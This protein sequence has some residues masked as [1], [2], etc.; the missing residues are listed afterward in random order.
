MSV[1][2]YDKTNVHM[3]TFNANIMWREKQYEKHNDIY[4]V[5]NDKK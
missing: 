5:G 4:K 2:F 1:L 3:F